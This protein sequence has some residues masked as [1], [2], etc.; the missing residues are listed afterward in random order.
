MF[1]E[2]ELEINESMINV[3]VTALTSLTYLFL[4]DMVLRNSGKILNIA[5]T[6]GFLP[7][8]LQAVYYATKA[9]VLSLSQAIAEELS[10]TNITVTVLCPGPVDTGFQERSQLEG[11]EIL[12]GDIASAKDV[13]LIGYE[14]MINGKLVVIDDLKLN[15]MLNWIVPLLPRRMLLKI[16]RQAMEKR[17]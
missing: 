6:A 14:A 4:K 15:F 5:S 11:A 8:P 10:N 16:S 12:K 13:A 2:Q 9:Y 3:N 1:H 7:G 17:T